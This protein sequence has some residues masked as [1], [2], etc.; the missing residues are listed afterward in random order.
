MMTRKIIHTFLII[1]LIGSQSKLY[2]QNQK[3]AGYMG[4]WYKSGRPYEYGYKYSGGLATFSSQHN[5]MA[6]YVPCEK[7]TFFVY[8]GT[9]G[10]D[11]SH[12]QIMIS[13]FDHRTHT[14]PRPVLVFDKD[15]VNDPQDNASLSIDSKGFIWV[16]ISGRGRTRPGYIFKSSLPYS[17]ESFEMM[18]QGEIVFP[19]AWWMRDSCFLMMQ[20]KVLNG[21]ELYWTSSTDGRNWEPV[22]KL[23]GMGGHF[24]VTNV[25]GNT[26]FSVFNYCP[27][28]NIDNRTNLYLLKTDDLGK[29]WKTIEDKVISTPLTDVK[30]DA[31]IRDYE[32]EKKKVYINDLN[33]DSNGNPVILA[34]ISK[35]F[36]PGP[37]G[38]PREWTVISWKNGKWEFSKICNMPHNYNLGS[39]YTAGKEW[40]IIGPSDAGP[41][42]YGTGGEMVLWTS[43]NEGK[44][45]VKSANI[46]YNSIY[47]NI[48]A[49]RPFQAGDDFYAFWA[50]GDIEKRSVSHLYFT[51]SRGDKVWVLPYNMKKD[52]E[53]PVR[54][55]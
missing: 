7:K 10:P 8:S 52:F 18:T 4:L 26:L 2:A 35:D 41:Q 13:Y 50:D 37:V 1:C 16:F 21:R 42:K 5:P 9:T 36:R 53:K 45:W 22:Q 28:G 39:L 23:A 34:I 20:T 17:I 24:Q 51:N 46:T 55:R 43:S 44:T 30:N 48:Y 19:Q 25:Y 11:T 49:R 29:S 6:I 14:V 32:S 15:G 3:A 12:L 31:M 27:G 33:F 38:D 47:N 40:K 54:I